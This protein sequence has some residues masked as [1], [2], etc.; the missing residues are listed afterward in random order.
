MREQ[1]EQCTTPLHPV[2]PELIDAFARTTVDR[3]A[4]AADQ[5]VLATHIETPDMFTEA[6]VLAVFQKY[7]F[8]RPCNNDQ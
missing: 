7:V 1:M 4:N 3:L 2:V 8:S 6:E 5:H